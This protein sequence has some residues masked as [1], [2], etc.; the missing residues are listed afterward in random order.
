MNSNNSFEE[1]QNNL[2]TRDIRNENLISLK[3][4][5][6]ILG[7]KYHTARSIIY[8]EHSIGYV[9]FTN[10]KRMW[11]LSDILNFKQK[12]YIQPFTA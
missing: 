4:V 9:Q 3:Q 6:E 5:A 1:Q 8:N 7:L 12:R 10:K 11:V 2:E